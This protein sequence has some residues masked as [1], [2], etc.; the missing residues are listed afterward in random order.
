MMISHF[1]W[2]RYARNKVKKCVRALRLCTIKE[3]KSVLA[4]RVDLFCPVDNRP[5]SLLL[6]FEVV[7]AWAPGR[8]A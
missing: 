7:C 8:L 6:P 1:S 5:A 2:I 4:A 3:A